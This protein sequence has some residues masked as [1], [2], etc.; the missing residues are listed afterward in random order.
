MNIAS[1]WDDYE[2]LDVAKGEKLERWGEVILIRPEPQVM[3]AKE[4]FPEKWKDASAR[5]SKDR[6]SSR[7]VGKV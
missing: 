3:R 7:R 2:L 4:S 6:T 5:F 1:K